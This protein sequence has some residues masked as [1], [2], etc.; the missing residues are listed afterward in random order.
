MDYTTKYRAETG[1]QEVS[2][3]HQLRPICPPRNPMECGYFRAG[4]GQVCKAP[5]ASRNSRRVGFRS[6][7]GCAS[8]AIRAPHK[9]CVQRISIVSLNCRDER[10]LGTFADHKGQYHPPDR[11]QGDPRL[12]IARG[13]AHPLGHGQGTPWYGQTSTTPPAGLR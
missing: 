5:L 7:E 2:Y 13:F 3:P 10:G 4:V 6:G 8:G 12:C 9:E 11:P 1:N